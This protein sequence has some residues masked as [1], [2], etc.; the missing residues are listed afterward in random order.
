MTKIYHITNAPRDIEE[1][2][3]RPSENIGR[4][5]DDER[6]INEVAKRENKEYPISRTN[7]NFFFPSLDV[8][9]YNYKREHVVVVDSTDISRNIF[10]A[11]RDIRDEIIFGEN[12]DENIISYIESISKTSPNQM[13]QSI[14]NI[15]GTPEIIIHGQIPPRKILEVKRGKFLE[16]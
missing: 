5:P 1:E 13:N 16:S 15:N 11:D 9:P 2:G 12:S 10:I 14:S 4:V 6:Q 8:I 7:A 3:F